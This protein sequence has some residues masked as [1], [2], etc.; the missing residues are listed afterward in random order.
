MKNI[1]NMLILMLLSANALAFNFQIS[2]QMEGH[3]RWTAEED[4]YGQTR[5]TLTTYLSGKTDNRSAY[6]SITLSNSLLDLTQANPSLGWSIYSGYLRV[7][8]PLLFMSKQ[9]VV[10]T[11]GNLWPSY[12]PYAVLLNG[13]SG[14]QSRKGFSLN[15]LEFGP[16]NAQGFYLWDTTG[17]VASIRPRIGYGTKISLGKGENSFDFI[18]AGYKN[19]TDLGLD[20]DSKKKYGLPIEEDIVMGFELK[21]K[22]FSQ[23]DVNGVWFEENYVKREWEPGAIGI[24]PKSEDKRSPKLKRLTV[25]WSPFY[26][27]EI[28]FD[29][30]DFEPGFRPRYAD[31][32]P[33]FYEDSYYGYNIL[34][35]FA[36]QKGYTIGITTGARNFVV[37]FNLERY[38]DRTQA[39]VP[40]IEKILAK[41][42]FNFMDYEID[43]KAKEMKST[44]RNVYGIS[45]LQ[46]THAIRIEA[47]KRIMVNRNLVLPKFI[48]H[49]EKEDSNVSK[50][51]IVGQIGFRLGSGHFRGLTIAAGVEK[52]TKLR[53]F[54]EGDFQTPGGINLTFRFTA[55]NQKEGTLLERWDDDFRSY[56]GFYPA[57]NYFK[58]ST[59]VKF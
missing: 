56:R 7:T 2:G 18:F 27:G 17:S 41:V 12:S 53:P 51:S 16:F 54:V 22:L 29:Y 43:A 6:Y 13:A 3:M 47:N 59:S 50:R 55:H 15:G 36:G 48:Y 30:R 38:R 44:E 9:E 24:T 20:S 10:Y 25:Q 23:F 14:N 57:D 28:V 21:S 34:D 39:E 8:A 11:I 19:R 49:I 5:T 52:R 37:G 45:S 42:N 31:H 33:M 26:R 35:R 58:A 40:E 4:L 32:R 1:I 46:Q